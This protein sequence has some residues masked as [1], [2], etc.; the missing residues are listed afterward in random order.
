MPCDPA[1]SGKVPWR[2]HR[3]SGR[4]GFSLADQ[5]LDYTATTLQPPFIKLFWQK[6]RLPAAERDPA[7]AEHVAAAFLNALDPLEQRRSETEWL[8]GD[9]F[10]IAD[11]G[12]G[13]LM[14]RA[15]DIAEPLD[16]P[17]LTRWYGALKERAAFR[18][19]ILTSYEELRG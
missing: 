1:P 10:S 5:W 14:K 4:S 18:E 13:S 9:R 8:A 3:A 12:P 6:V 15:C 16:N 19:T 2:H 11:I 7:A 17:P